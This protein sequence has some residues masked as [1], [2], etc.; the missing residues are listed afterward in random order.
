[1][2]SGSIITYDENGQQ[3]MSIPCFGTI[4]SNG[5]CLSTFPGMTLGQCYVTDIYGNNELLP[6]VLN[7]N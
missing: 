2:G 6:C 7:Y 4:D 5:N 1:M 3:I